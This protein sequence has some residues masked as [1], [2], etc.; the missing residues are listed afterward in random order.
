LTRLFE[1]LVSATLPESEGESSTDLRKE[2]VSMAK[3]T[4]E[5]S[6]QEV[7]EAKYLTFMIGQVSYALEIKI[8]TEI[9]GLQK[10]TPVPNVPVFI[11]GVINLRGKVIPVMDVRARFHLEEQSYHDRTCIIVIEIDGSAVGLVVDAVSEVLDLPEQ[12]I[13]PTP[14]LG[15]SPE[16]RCI[17]GLGKVGDEVKLI[18]NAKQLLE[19][20][21]AGLLQAKAT[22]LAS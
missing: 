4:Q 7:T 19:A 3:A 22:D 9:I 1:T 5:P 16:S 18:L 17:S 10:I 8:V 12:N 11:K 13:E 2:R 6:E 14:A 15:Q 21:E 20:G